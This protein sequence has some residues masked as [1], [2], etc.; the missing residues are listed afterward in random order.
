[1]LDLLVRPVYAN[2]PVCIVTVGGGLLLAKKL[3]IDDLL[4]SIWLSGLNTAIAFFIASKAKQ[5]LLSNP[6]YM[7]LFFYGLT[8]VYLITTKQVGHLRNTFMGVDKVV[9]GMT[10]GFIIFLLSVF[11][12]KAIRY[13][14]NKKVLF[15]YQ[16]VV[17]PVGFLAIMTGIMFFL[18][19]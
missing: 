11:T 4:V 2:C 3:G 17:V 5:K 6:L 14:N 19:K 8:M 13:Y 18:I 10:L 7:S 15:P 1:M 16:K 9:F 12:D